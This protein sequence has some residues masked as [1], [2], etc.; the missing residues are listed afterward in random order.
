MLGRTPHSGG[1]RQDNIIL[2]AVMAGTDTTFLQQRIYT[3]LSGGEKQRV[4]LA[5][6][7]AQ[8]WGEDKDQPRLLLLDEPTAA[9]DLAHKQ[10]I[11]D[12]LRKLAGTGCAI[13]LVAHDF[14]LVGAVADQITALSDGQ[15]VAQGSPESVLTPQVFSKIFG[16]EV[17]ITEHPK[18]GRPLVISL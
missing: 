14:N 4:Q 11:L 17:S 8:I 12:T 5:R 13:V 9:L 15:Q 16:V 6:V 18:T 10:L 7:F 3:Q 2:Q 1:V